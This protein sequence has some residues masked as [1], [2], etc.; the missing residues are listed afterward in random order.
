MTKASKKPGRKRAAEASMP[1]GSSMSGVSKEK[2]KGRAAKATTKPPNAGK[3]PRNRETG[4]WAGPGSV[5]DE[6]RCKGTARR[7]GERC[8]KAAI[9]GHFYCKF[10]GGA[11]PS[12]KQTARQRLMAM[13]E[14]AM[15]ALEKVL[16]DPSTDDNTKVRAALGILDRTGFRPGIV[17]V[18]G[19]PSK[20][21]ELAD[22]GALDLDP[23][24][25]ELGVGYSPQALE[26]SRRLNMHQLALDAQADVDRVRHDE[27]THEYLEGRIWPDENTI[28]GEVITPHPR[29]M[30]GLDEPVAGGAGPFADVR[31]PS[32]R[33]EHDPHGNEP[34]PPRGR[35]DPP[36]YERRRARFAPPRD[37]HE[38]RR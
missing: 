38:D 2:S 10:H 3:G 20:W 18:P 24:L 35:N 11:L 33:S 12:V 19:E 25:S 26:E 37:P 13:A 30:S 22:G 17:I 5:H 6:R 16:S 9:P 8:K 36:E 23:D 7:T 15:A 1:K 29:N 27:D 31:P 34:T 14:P 4:E 32:T 28:Q 21:D